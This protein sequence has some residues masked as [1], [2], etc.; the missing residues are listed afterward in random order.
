MGK[1]DSFLVE[2]LRLQVLSQH[3]K[4]LT[5]SDGTFIPKGTHLF[6]LTYV[7]HHDGSV[8]EDPVVFDPFHFFLLRDDGNENAGHQMVGMTQDYLPFGWG[9]HACPERHLPANMLKIMLVHILTSCDVKLE[10][11]LRA[12]QHALGVGYHTGSHC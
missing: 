3:T 2:T 9:K 7:F 5:L 11:S 4:N 6:V 12:N 8:Y 10:D 1:V